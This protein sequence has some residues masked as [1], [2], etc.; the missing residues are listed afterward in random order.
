MS[1][2][3]MVAGAR[4]AARL[5]AFLRR[6]LTVGEARAIVRRRLGAR[7]TD[8]LTLARTAIYDRPESPYRQLLRLAGCEYGDLAGL[9]TRDGL[10]GALRVLYRRGVYLTVEEFKGLRPVVRGSASVEVDP[11]RCRNPLITPH[12]AV[13]S[14]GSRGVRTFIPVPLEFV[15]DR[16]VNK[17]LALNARGGPWHLAHWDVP[18][19]GLTAVLSSCLAGTVPERW[20]SPV[21]PYDSG[22]HPRYRWSA[23]DRPAG[24]VC[25]PVAP[26]PMPRST[27]PSSIALE[28]IAPMDERRRCGWEPRP[29]LI[30]VRPAPVVR[31]CRAAAQPRAS[32]FAGAQFRLSIGEPLTAGSTRRRSTDRSRGYCRPMPDQR[33]RTTWAATGLSAIAAEVD[34]VHFLSDLHGVVQPGPGGESPELPAN[35]L[36]FSSLRPS[37]TFV[38]LNVSMGD[39]AVMSARSCGCPLSLSLDDA[40]PR[41]PPPGEAHRGG[42]DVLDADVIRV[43]EEVLP[44]RFGGAP[45]D[46]Q[47][48]EDEGADAGLASRWWCTRR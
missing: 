34:E 24:E 33:N 9:V 16:A 27:C 23:R 40:P 6:P 13:Q 35:T 5:P 47:L 22:V 45:T 4:F 1:F 7:E 20:F 42:N 25:W 48:V 3:E 44:G 46:Y 17:C 8:F 2:T 36:L 38:L 28:P 26:L 29:L 11:A 14:G 19:G 21:D 43:L 10:E 18:G 30:G 32:T 12:V 41:R 15:R 31:L 37:T 39:Q